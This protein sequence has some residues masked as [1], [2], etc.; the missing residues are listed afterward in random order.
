MDTFDLRQWPEFSAAGGNSSAPA[1]I[2]HVAIDSRRIHSTKTLFVALPG[3]H[4]DGHQF[5]AQAAQAGA[6]YI[7]A[8]SDWQ[9]SHHISNATILRVENPLKALQ[10]I[11]HIYRKQLSAKFVV[12]AGSYGKTMVK[13]LLQSLLETKKRVAASP[14]SFNSQIGVALSIFT[15]KK[16]HDIALIEAGISEKGEMERLMHMISPDHT[17]VTHVGKKHMATL[18]NFETIANEIMHA[19]NCIKSD[20][21][22]IVPHQFDLIEQLGRIRATPYYWSHRYFN[23]PMALEVTNSASAHLPYRL[24]FPDGSFF[25]NKT[26]SGFYYFLDLINITT[27]AAWLLGAREEGIRK[28]LSR[29]VAEP[30]R[31]EI[32]RSPIGTTFIN[33]IYS[34]DPQSVERSLRY[35]DQTTLKGRK[36]FVFEGLRGPQENSENNYQRIGQMICSSN[37]DILLLVGK[38]PFEPIL[39]ET[40]NHSRSID[41][42]FCSN[43][44]HAIAHLLNIVRQDDVVLIKGT[45]KEPLDELTEAFNDSICTNQCLINLAAIEANIVTLRKKLPPETRMLVMVKALAYGTNDIRM[46][47]F[48]ATCGVDILGVSYVDEAVALKRAGISQ[49]IFV[50]N[51]AMYEA[52]KVVKW[53]LE[54]GVSEKEFIV[55]LAE[56]AAQHN[57]QINVHLHVDTGMSRFGCRSEEALELAQLIS[58]LPS[59][60]LEGIMTHF[61]CADDPT[62]D[63]FT[64]KQARAFDKVISKI[65]AAGI[66]LKWCHAANSSAAMRFHFPTYNMV[67]IG[68]AVYGLYPSE[69]TKAALE[70]RL[71]I[72]LVSR[73][74]GINSCQAGETISYG[75]SYTVSKEQ[76]RIAVLPIGYF[77]GLH[78]NYSGRGSVIVRGK[79]APMVGKICMD[80]MMVDITEISNAE[81]GDSVLIFGENEYGEY[82]SPEELAHS[83]DSIIYELITCL[84]PRIQRIFIYEEAYQLR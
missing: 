36:I 77:D 17:I 59:L 2:D 32:W 13:D 81:I 19:A 31:T 22:V 12:I 15:V 10:E 43:H 11:A 7:L 38:H 5:I 41:T 49:A 73:I 44:Q 33:D 64:K 9:P 58:S 75:R 53:D 80:F 61:A 51:A 28:V 42:I 45:K 69:A 27:K 84:G 30:M 24:E 68:L 76:Q 63:A 20:Q 54:V 62:Q 39:A 8:R 21:W 74:V 67:R 56:E 1:W 83:G 82:I 55:A 50:I 78:R 35:L 48:L 29:Y 65:R 52:S 4:V 47:H 40:K 60:N 70:L 25:V 46:S 79:K 71:A 26:T 34:S 72:S 18:G 14:E 57:K 3:E 37:V 23:L 66:T 16:E 6:H